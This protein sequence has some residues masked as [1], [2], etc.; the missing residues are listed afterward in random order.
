MGTH[1]GGLVVDDVLFAHHAR[2]G[3]DPSRLDQFPEESAMAHV[4]ALILKKKRAPRNSRVSKD[5]VTGAEAPIKNMRL[6]SSYSGP[7]RKILEIAKSTYRLILATANGFPSED[8][9]R[10]LS[11]RAY[12]VGHRKVLG[13]DLDGASFALTL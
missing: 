7:S 11:E 13:P 6:L 8:M 9:R 5:S 10:V 3:G 2:N 12:A 1:N 4:G